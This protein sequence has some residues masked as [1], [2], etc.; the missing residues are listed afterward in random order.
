MRRFAKGVT[1]TVAATI[2]LNRDALLR[3]Q[4]W[5]MAVLDM[6]LEDDT[7]ETVTAEALHQEELRVIRSWSSSYEQDSRSVCPAADPSREYAQ[8]KLRDE[9]TRIAR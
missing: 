8:A 4:E 7:E 1:L 6:S 3:E 2:A 5:D 9:R